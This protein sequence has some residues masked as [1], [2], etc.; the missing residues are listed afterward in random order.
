MFVCEDFPT[1]VAR[2]KLR[3]LKSANLTRQ[4]SLCIGY[5]DGMAK[6]TQVTAPRTTRSITDPHT[7]RAIAHPVRMR[8][9][10]L[11]VTGGPATA[12]KLSAHVPAAPGSLSYHLRELAEYG[13]IE[14]APELSHD[15]RE[16]WWR[17]IPG[18]VR[19]SPSDFLDNPA[20]REALASAQQVLVARQLQRLHSW[21]TDGAEQWGPGW[22]DAAIAVDTL[23]DL[24]QEE[25][26]Q[27]GGELDAVIAR[28]AERSR[29]RRKDSS[30]S[31]DQ[32]QG[33]EQ[34][35]VFTH[36]FPFADKLDRKPPSD[37]T[38][39]GEASS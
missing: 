28:W 31:G 29:Q 24:N 39:A 21:H 18:G 8:L 14:E 11:L 33:R 25:L 37:D 6:N 20:E 23:L 13:Y 1:V 12:S 9:Y 35:F 36:A 4:I 38:G 30:G 2:Q 16:R 22:A 26:H 27:L 15:K 5:D 3:N 19:W 17:A 34:V 7:L 10:E 32:A